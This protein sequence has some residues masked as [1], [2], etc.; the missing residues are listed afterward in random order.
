MSARFTDEAAT[1]LA[2]REC[3]AL[4]DEVRDLARR[5][6]LGSA[7]CL[8]GALCCA[9]CSRNLAF[10]GG[11]VPTSLM[12]DDDLVARVATG[13][14]PVGVLVLGSARADARKPVRLARGVVELARHRTRWGVWV[15]VVGCALHARLRLRDLIDPAAVARVAPWLAAG[16]PGDALVHDLATSPRFADGEYDYLVLGALYG[17]PLWSS[18]AL[19]RRAR[20][21]KDEELGRKLDGLAAAAWT[22]M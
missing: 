1:T 12:D 22:A 21:K 17:Y 4:F 18:V 8:R 14:K 3:A 6:D 2:R 5:V 13:L 9:R 16:F 7:C 10:R 20:K 15:A 11:T 19:A